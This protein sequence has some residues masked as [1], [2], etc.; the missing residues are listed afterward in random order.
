MS[1]LLSRLDQ[2]LKR[3]IALPWDE[4]TLTWD[5]EAAFAIDLVN[6]YPA[7]AK[8]LRAAERLVTFAEDHIPFPGK[9]YDEWR[10]AVAESEG[11][12]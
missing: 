2:R 11:E 3:L 10:R 5:E 8:R 4:G 9:L 7:L 1:D 12:S 6:A